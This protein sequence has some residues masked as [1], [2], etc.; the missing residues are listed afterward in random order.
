MLNSILIGI[1]L[2]CLPFF[3]LNASLDAVSSEKEI[4]LWEADSYDENSRLQE[5]IAQNFLNLLEDQFKFTQE[6]PLLLD[7]G[8][9][10]G[11]I[12]NT[13]FN[14]FPGVQ[15]L[16]IDSS[17]DMIRFANN[18]FENPKM[19][20]CVDRAEE[21]S[22]IQSGSIDAITSFSCLHWVLDQQSAFQKMYQSLKPSGWIGLM[23]A[24]ETG[25]DDPIDHAFAQAIQEAPWNNYFQESTVQADWNLSKPENIKKQL[26]EIGFQIVSMGIQNFD[27]YFESPLIFQNWILAC[28]QQLKVLPPDLQL[29]CAKRIAE[30]YLKSTSDRQPSNH[31]CIYQVDAFMLMAI[32]PDYVNSHPHSAET[33]ILKQKDQ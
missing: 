20:F 22:T 33:S 6:T 18:H 1:R 2:V 8:C 11:R 14:T 29:S 25:F 26:E 16:G 19:T 28:A 4:E 23:F 24:A 13:V 31:Q 21:L 3:F 32:K 12:T 5:T 7:I 30:L 17:T 27:Y 10:N 15:I 9:G